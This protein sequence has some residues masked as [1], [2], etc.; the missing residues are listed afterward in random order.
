[1][2]LSITFYLV[3]VISNFRQLLTVFLHVKYDCGFVNKNVTD[4]ISFWLKNDSVEH[5]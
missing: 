2:L 5:I 3:Q 1:M 4:T